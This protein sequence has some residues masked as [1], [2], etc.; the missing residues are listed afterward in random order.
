[1]HSSRYARSYHRESA[2]AHRSKRLNSGQDIRA[3]SAGGW[4]L[5]VGNRHPPAG[6]QMTRSLMVP[7]QRSAR[8][9]GLA[10]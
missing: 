9:V 5:R 8:G 4:R 1:M 6:S 3:S 7:T 10:A 2:P